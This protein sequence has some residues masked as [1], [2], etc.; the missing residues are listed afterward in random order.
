MS[1]R[2]A[3]PNGV[4]REEVQMLKEA[5]ITVRKQNEMKRSERLF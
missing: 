2:A 4:S 3:V 1:T 5:I